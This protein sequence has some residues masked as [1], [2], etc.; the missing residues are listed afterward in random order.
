ME[1]GV[2]IVLNWFRDNNKKAGDII[3]DQQ[4]L[5]LL[6]RYNIQERIDYDNTIKDLID[7]GYLKINSKRLL[8]LTPKGEMEIYQ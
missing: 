3:T 7:I 5:N 4:L 8:A 1:Q 6:T 2:K